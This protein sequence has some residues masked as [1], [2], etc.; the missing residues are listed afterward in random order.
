MRLHVM[1]LALIV[2]M[3]APVLA[4]D[5][6]E[7]IVKYRKDYMTAL[8]GHVV[9]AVLHNIFGRILCQNRCTHRHD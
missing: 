6:P 5:T 1:A 7:N 4:E 3:S 8:G 2:A 9:L